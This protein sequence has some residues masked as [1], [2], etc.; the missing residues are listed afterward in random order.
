MSQIGRDTYNT[1]SYAKK[2]SQHCS[3]A[4]N[5]TKRSSYSSLDKPSPT[6]PTVHHNKKYSTANVLNPR[7]SIGLK[8]S[9]LSNTGVN[10]ARP[11]TPA[12]RVSPAS[13]KTKMSMTKLAPKTSI[14]PSPLN[15]EIEQ[16]KEL[17]NE[18]V[19]FGRELLQRVQYLEDELKTTKQQCSELIT[20]STSSP[21][22]RKHVLPNVALQK[23]PTSVTSSIETHIQP[24]SSK[25]AVHKRIV[26][27]TNCMGKGVGNL[28]SKV[29]NKN[30]TSFAYPNANFKYC[31]KGLETLP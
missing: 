27:I 25:T 19:S 1:R 10:N 13:S 5:G 31:V 7:T 21:T 23:N 24:G 26:I 20:F 22:S 4:A 28:L 30:V 8:P 29:P 11:I 9:P 14:A 17:N 15:K 18:L 2:L 3:T 6:R 12:K 16:L